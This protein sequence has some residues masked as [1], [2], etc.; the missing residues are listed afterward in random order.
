MVDMLPHDRRMLF[1]KSVMRG[2]SARV[3]RK[4]VQDFKL[5]EENYPINL[6]VNQPVLLVSEHPDD[7][8]DES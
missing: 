6:N 7:T 8:K 1:E 2:T 3:L 5:V 4:L